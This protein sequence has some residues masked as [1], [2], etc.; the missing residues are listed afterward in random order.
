MS[1]V[2]ECVQNLCYFAVNVH[3]CIQVYPTVSESM[4]FIPCE[5]VC[6]NSVQN[7][8]T[9]D[10]VQDTFVIHKYLKLSGDQ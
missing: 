5:L 2:E 6:V 7:E 4:C 10:L 9:D 1:R 8:V 3:A